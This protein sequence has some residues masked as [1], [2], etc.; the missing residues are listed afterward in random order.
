MADIVM[1]DMKETQGLFLITLDFEML[2]GIEVQK[3]SPEWRMRVSNVHAVIP[4]LLD[5]FEQYDVSATF[6]SVGMLFHVDMASVRTGCPDL[7]PSYEN[8]RLSPY[9]FLSQLGEDAAVY[10]CGRH[11]LDEIAESGRHEIASHTYCHYYC[12]AKGQM[13]EQFRADLLKNIAVAAACGRIIDSLVFPRNEFNPTYLN[14]CKEMGITVVRS[15]SSQWM[16]KDGGQMGPWLPRQIRRA[17]RLLDCYVGP[18][19]NFSP[20][21]LTVSPVVQV[22]ASRFLRPV[23]KSGKLFESLR[24]KHIKNEMTH[25]AKHGL[26]YQLWWHPHNMG[27]DMDE[28]FSFLEKILS[29]YS[30]LRTDYD[31]RSVTMNYF[32]S[33]IK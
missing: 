30:H 26:G 27:T 5:L 1:A 25:A 2:W 28:N 4:R 12:L 22:P 7:L 32:K 15:N 8:D 18:Y 20:S 23:S 14:I 33:I 9:R 10:Y 3:A 21:D 16:W 17:C 24:L 29:H 13:P 19:N 31:F 11:L 6:A